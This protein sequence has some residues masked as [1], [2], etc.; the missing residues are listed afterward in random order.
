LD[1]FIALNVIEKKDNIGFVT[2]L[3]RAMAVFDTYP[4]IA[5]MLIAGYNYHCRDEVVIL[6]AI[7]NMEDF[8]YKMDSI[9]LRF[10]PTTKN[11]KEKS[12]E[13]KK[14]DKIKK[15]WTN[16]M[17]DQFSLLDIYNAFYERK[18]DTVDRRTG[19]IIRERKGDAKQWCKEN[20]LHFNT[21]EKI[22]Q[23]AKDIQRKFGK[24]IQIFREKHPENKPTHIFLDNPPEIS[25][26]K[27]ENI[28][29]AIFDGYYINLLKKIGNK[30][31]NCFP[32]VKTIT[33]LPMDSLFAGIKSKYNYA[34]YSELKSI[35]GRASY[36]I[37]ANIPPSYIKNLMDSKKG[38]VVADCFK[39]MDEEKFKK[40]T[41][42]GRSRSRGR[43]K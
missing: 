29:K 19:R 10:K 1:R 25:E 9:F 22:K 18:Y 4:E 26:K 32:P 24:V 7:Y 39:K 35:F 17:G 27:E 12:E 21:L 33:G 41:K 20:Y 2:D 15:K 8:R 5:R 31:I 11:E 43:K 34:I 6:A 42:R 3:G 14:Y 13:K 36:A 37:V 40:K 30:Y 38:L 28:L 23:E 16:S